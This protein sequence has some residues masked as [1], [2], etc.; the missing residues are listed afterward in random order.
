MSNHQNL[1]TSLRNLTLLLGSTTIILAAII[2]SPALPSM[3][4]AF[5]DVPNATFLVRL[6][7]T[8]PALFIAI[9]ALFV[10]VLLDRWG[11][12]PVLIVSLIL[13]GL[14]GTVGFF[15]DSLVTILISR[16]LL[17]LSVAGVASSLV[18]LIIDYFKAN[19][20]SQFL[21]WQGAIMG[22]GG[23]VFLLLGGFLADVGWRYPFLVHLFAFFILPGAIFFIEE[24]QITAVHPAPTIDKVTFPWRKLAPIYLTAFVGMIIYY[25]FLVQI[26][27]YLSSGGDI[28]SSQVGIALSL[29]TFIS[30][31]LALQYQ[32][33]KKRFSFQAIF[34][35]VFLAFS[36]NHLIISLS[37]D[38]LIVVVGLLF[39]GAGIGLFPPANSDWLAAEAPP[40][41][42]GKAVG[43]QTSTV[44]IGQFFSPIVAQPFILRLGLANTFT[45]AAAAAFLITLLF[46]LNTTRRKAPKPAKAL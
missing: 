16:A 3:A 21:G 6:S 10:G 39:G 29:Q 31:F 37:T 13:Y 20:L 22:L 32:R 5:A 38:Y 14:I 35:L 41:L 8:M 33:L 42:R 19:Q 7:L 2:I 24:P 46:F 27:F 40:E 9:G 43:L 30:I 45:L 28:S 36:L 25:I 34:A 15:L 4:K 12:K 1:S 44:F 11:R 26:P 18:T 17:G 23:V